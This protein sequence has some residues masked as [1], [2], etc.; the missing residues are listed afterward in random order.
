MYTCNALNSHDKH[1]TCG[2]I[3]THAFLESYRGA[4]VALGG[5][6]VRNC[7]PDGKPGSDSDG[8]LPPAVPSIS[9][10]V[11]GSDYQ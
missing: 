4:A 3:F 11:P 6:G 2:V 7:L 1:L 8:G 9:S 10:S 5:S